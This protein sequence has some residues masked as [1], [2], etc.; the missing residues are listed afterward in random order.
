MADLTHVLQVDKQRDQVMSFS[1]VMWWLLLGAAVAVRMYIVMAP[2]GGWLAQGIADDSFYYLTIARNLANGS[3]FTFDGL[4]PTNGFHPLYVLLLTPLF[5]LFPA[6]GL[7]PVYTSQIIVLAL[8]LAAALPLYYLLNL[9]GGQRAGRAGV[10]VWLFNPWGLIITVSGV[11]S[12][13]YALCILLVLYAYARWRLQPDQRSAGAPALIGALLGLTILAR[14]DGVFLGAALGLDLLL[15]ASWSQRGLRKRVDRSLV[16]SGLL[17]MISAAAVLAPWFY[18]NWVTFGSLVQVSGQAVYWHMH[19]RTAADGTAANF[20][21]ALLSWVR[22]IFGSMYFSAAALVLLL[23][24][25]ALRLMPGARRV[26]V[27]QA[28]KRLL[29]LSGLYG[30]FILGFY[31][32]YL[33]QQQFWYFMPVLVVGAV[34]AG[35]LCAWICDVFAVVGNARAPRFVELGLFLVILFTFFPVWRSW[36]SGVLQIYPAQAN[37]YRLAEKLAQETPPDAVIGA[38]NS[39]IL[40]YFSERTVINLDG[41]VNNMLHQEIRRQGT[42]YFDLCAIWGYI[43]GQGIQYLTDY[44]NVFHVDTD[45]IFS[46]SMVRFLELKGAGNSQSQGVRVYRV[47]NNAEQPSINSCPGP[48]K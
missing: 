23:V 19:A 13:L 22:T 3:G 8:N 35:V 31:G 1:K 29:T 36:Q 18:W 38:W 16:R 43:Q 32:A 26:A 37:A 28:G 25:V 17:I 10:L 42:R 6:G 41:V 2:P 9:V 20:S 46:G 47:V 5:W 44:E 39:G 21:A 30:I 7:P 4:L 24:A 45:Q 33:W 14:S 15:F 40:G 34:F 48:Y 27:P 12:A 11:E